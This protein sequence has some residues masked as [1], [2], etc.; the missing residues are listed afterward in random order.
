MAKKIV[1][2]VLGLLVMALGFYGLI[3]LWWPQFAGVFLGLLGPAIF[4][5]GLIIFFIGWSAEE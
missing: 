1:L 5:V 3:V 4:L 2:L